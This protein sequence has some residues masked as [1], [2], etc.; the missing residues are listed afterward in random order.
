MVRRI[1]V[2]T[3]CRCAFL[4]ER[5]IIVSGRAVTSRFSWKEAARR[6]GASG[7]LHAA[8]SY[9]HDVVP[10]RRRGLPVAWINRKGE[11]VGRAGEPDHELRTLAELADWLTGSR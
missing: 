6:I 9:F 7:W 1:A 8:Q 10:A 11:P 3:G 4:M 5:P 2:I